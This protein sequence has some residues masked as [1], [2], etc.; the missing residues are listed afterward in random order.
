MYLVNSEF[1][2]YFTRVDTIQYAMPC[3]IRVRYIQIPLHPVLSSSWPSESYASANY[4]VISSGNWLSIVQ[5]QPIIWVNVCLLLIGHLETNFSE[6]IMETF[7][8]RKMRL[9]IVYKMAILPQSRYVNSLY[10]A[11]SHSEA[12][13]T[14][15]VRNEAQG[16]APPL[17]EYDRPENAEYRTQHL[18]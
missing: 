4:A 18:M 7:S 11:R 3:H 6:I 15:G 10:R 17:I 2:P 9:K 1:D 13:D 5:R 8:L 12:R 16:N 14:N